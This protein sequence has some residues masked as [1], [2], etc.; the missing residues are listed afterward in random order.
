[1]SSAAL[2]SYFFTADNK[3]YNYSKKYS[4]RCKVKD[5]VKHLV[6]FVTTLLMCSCGNSSQM[7]CRAT[8]Y[9][10]IFLG[11]DTVGLVI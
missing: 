5:T 2:E 9:S 4:Y 3:Q 1:M 10:L 8:F 6:K 7:V 11:F